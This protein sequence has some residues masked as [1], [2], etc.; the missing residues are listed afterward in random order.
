MSDLEEFFREQIKPYEERLKRLE[1]LDKKK[2]V[3]I[4]VLKLAIENMQKQIKELKEQLE[5]NKLGVSK[6][7]VKPLTGTSTKKK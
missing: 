2:D 5:N 4:N 1:E 7:G 3:E 6:P